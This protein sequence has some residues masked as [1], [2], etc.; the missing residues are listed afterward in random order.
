VIYHVAYPGHSRVETVCAD[1]PEE[2]ARIAVGR[3]NRGG[4]VEVRVYFHDVAHENVTVPR[5]DIA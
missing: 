3:G 5:E 1:S 2:A 4:A